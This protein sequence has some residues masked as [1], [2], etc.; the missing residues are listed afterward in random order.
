MPTVMIA[1]ESGTD[2]SAQMGLMRNWFDT[3]RCTPSVFKYR[4]DAG[5]IVIQVEFIDQE[6]ALRFKQN[7]GGYGQQ[8]KVSINARAVSDPVGSPARAR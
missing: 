7:F 3:H 6:T 1:L 8:H 5:V 4:H 2:L